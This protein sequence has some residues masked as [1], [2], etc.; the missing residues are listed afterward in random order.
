MK[1]INRIHLAKVPYEIEIE[2]KDELN[3]YFD[4]LKK[5][6]K[7]ET[8][9][10]DV[11][12]R[13][14]EILRDQGV[15]A[16][17]I[18]SSRDI[19]KIKAQLGSPEVFMDDQTESLDTEG[20]D[21]EQEADENTSI[22]RKLFRDE[23]N[24]IIGGVASGLSLYFDIDV[25]LIRVVMI[26]LI[27]A[28]A[29]FVI[30]VYFLLWIAIPKAK[31]ATDIL[32]L[33]GQKISARALKEINQ[34][35]NFARIN[36]RSKT[37]L[38]VLRVGLTVITSLMVI[39]GLIALV[40][41]NMAIMNQFETASL[42]VP[43]YENGIMVLPHILINIAGVSFVI[44]SAI[45]VV[46][47]ATFKAKQSQLVALGMLVFAGI[48]SFTGG[49][50]MFS[51][52]ENLTRQ[53]IEQSV[54]RRSIEIDS[55]KLANIKS[56][57]IDHN[58]TVEYIVSDEMRAEQYRYDYPDH[59]AYP[60]FEFSGDRLIIKANRADYGT[61]RSYFSSKH[62]NIVI[63]GPKLE[64]IEEFA[65]SSSREGKNTYE[66]VQASYI[67]SQD[68][69]KL[70]VKLNE[71]SNFEI[72]GRQKI[73]SLNLELGDLASFSAPNIS[74]EELKITGLRST[75]VRVWS[76]GQIALNG[77]FRCVDNFDNRNGFELEYNNSPE[78][79]LNGEKV[80]AGQLVCSESDQDEMGRG[81]QF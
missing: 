5:N 49:A 17:G 44:F 27:F 34:E 66:P 59:K 40:T 9:L 41:G 57:Q 45:L 35:Y 4:A 75:G 16:G 53:S 10:D 22:R 69:A 3:K 14:T 62:E 18:I 1:E 20:S 6:I 39:G 33:K 37:I 30:P 26:A 77:Q 52:S 11:E 71:D 12:I 36:R 21:N 13:I 25:A 78:I 79:T 76:A 24:A 61:N 38:N 51:A 63:Y 32:Q 48:S 7:D 50:A 19:E 67:L 72:V 80:K 47:S 64:M 42:S 60:K 46:M 81:Q 58:L 2:A 8:I 74:V 70:T 68:Q 23:L 55:E 54:E 73:E 43:G 15:A 56:L 28:T 29:G 65:A 31:N